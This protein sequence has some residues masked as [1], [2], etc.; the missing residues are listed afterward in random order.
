[1]CLLERHRDLSFQTHSLRHTG[2][3]TEELQESEVVLSLLDL[4][5]HPIILMRYILAVRLDCL[6]CFGINSLST[7]SARGR[8]D[9]VCCT[10]GVVISCSLWL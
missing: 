10:P 9:Q 6:T 5:S 1:M 7:S 2:A 3:S 8:S 4:Q